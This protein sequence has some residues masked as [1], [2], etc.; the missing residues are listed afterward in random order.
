MSRRRPR[1]GKNNAEIASFA[2]LGMTF[3]RRTFETMVPMD[4]HAALTRGQVN[5]WIDAPHELAIRPLGSADLIR[6]T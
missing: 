4:E 1:L 6:R 3:L 5:L 2:A